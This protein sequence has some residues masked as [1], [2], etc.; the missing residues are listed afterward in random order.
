[1]TS[2]KGAGRGLSRERPHLSQ[3]TI[4]AGPSHAAKWRKPNDS[5]LT[6]RHP[7]PDPRG[8]PPNHVNR[9]LTLPFVASPATPGQPV[10]GPLLLS[11]TPEHGARCLHHRHRTL[12]SGAM[13]SVLRGEGWRTV[14]P[15]TS[16]RC[17]A[18]T[19]SPAACMCRRCCWSAG[20]AGDEG[21]FQVERS[22]FAVVP[23]FEFLDL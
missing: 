18:T 11:G 2:R 20:E 7:N 4:S 10:T 6:A 12:K 15:S 13:L 19:R 9:E 14:D 23:Q 21:T 16:R 1:M 22:E 8:C 5:G 17:I 3:I